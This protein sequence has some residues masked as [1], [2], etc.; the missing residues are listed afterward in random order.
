MIFLKISRVLIV[1][2]LLIIPS[3]GSWNVVVVVVVV[4]E[5]EVVGRVEVYFAK[6]EFSFTETNFQGYLVWT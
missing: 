6:I 1:E 2:L 3:S 5:V 4:V